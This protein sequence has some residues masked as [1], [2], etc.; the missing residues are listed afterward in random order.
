M[1]HRTEMDKGFGTAF[2]LLP[3]FAALGHHLLPIQ[4]GSVAIYGFRQLLL[5]LV[6]AACFLPR[7]T[8][9]RLEPST[10]SAIKGMLLWVCWAAFSLLW[11]PEFSGATT[12]LVYLGLAFAVIAVVNWNAFCRATLLDKLCT[13][14]TLS[15]VPL[16]LIVAAEFLAGRRLFGDELVRSS[17]DA[18]GSLFATFHNANDFSGFLVLSVPFVL[19]FVFRPWDASKKKRSLLWLLLLLPAPV[20]VFLNGSRISMLG[21]GAELA[22][23]YLGTGGHKASRFGRELSLLVKIALGLLV[24]DLCSSALYSGSM[25]VMREIDT[26]YSAGIRINLVLNGLWMLWDS[27]LMGAGPGG[28]TAIHEADAMP[29]YTRGITNPHCFFV[30][31]LSQYGVAVF[32]VFFYSVFSI[33]W[34]KHASLNEQ[35]HRL[36]F[37]VRMAAVGFLFSAFANASHMS[38]PVVW[39]FVASFIALAAR[40]YELGTKGRGGGG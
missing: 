33:S 40:F 8:L 20:V 6:F 14:W 37:F 13:G 39:T 15:L 2:V 17:L 36:I 28:F 9:A 4:V 25:R 35:Q 3:T 1:S 34:K 11:A 32:S 5:L 16:W 12:D 18:Q 23:V 31:V 21:I 26:N 22:L 29:Y 19:L 10:R 7:P 30:E 38:S 27:M 24:L